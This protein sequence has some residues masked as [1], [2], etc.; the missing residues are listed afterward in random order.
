MNALLVRSFNR[1]SAAAVSREEQGLGT[2]V[3]FTVA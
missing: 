2:T 3:T 1:N